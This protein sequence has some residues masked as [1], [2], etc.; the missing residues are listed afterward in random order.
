VAE[1]RDA[2]QVR[3]MLNFLWMYERIKEYPAILGGV[4]DILA[5]V[6]K[7]AREER[8]DEDKLSIV[9]GDFWT[10]K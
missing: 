2:P 4:A 7:A 5:Q 10:G 9:H 1:N 6:E 8:Q 3:H